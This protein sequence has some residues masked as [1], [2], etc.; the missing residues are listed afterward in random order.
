MTGA[1][2]TGACQCG[3]VR[4]R[5]VG[6]PAHSTVC[7]CENCRRAG[8]AQAV[9]WWTFAAADFAFTAGEPEHYTTA[10][11]GR[12]TFCRRCGS[13]LT[14]VGA[15]RP[16]EVDVTAG[17]ADDPERYPPTADNFPED[18]LSW[19]PTTPWTGPVHA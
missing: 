19:V 16:D 12:R 13:Q 4:W 8:G 11:G 9:A 5:A 17:T 10:A 15:H 3:Q 18:R 6:E 14:Y 1:V 2:T 7:H